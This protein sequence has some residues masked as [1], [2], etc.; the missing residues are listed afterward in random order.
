MYV[1]QSKSYLKHIDFIILDV[2]CSQIALIV[3]YC[4]YNGW[5]KLVYNRHEYVILAELIPAAGSVTTAALELYSGILRRG[6]LKEFKYILIQAGVTS[7]L[8]TSVLFITKESSLYS[9]AILIGTAILFVVIAFPVRLLRKKHLKILEG[10]NNFKEV[11][12][13]AEE[14]KLDEICDNI[15][16]HSSNLHIKSTI[17]IENI[18][19][20]AVKADILQREWI[21]EVYI[22][23]DRKS[24]E[25]K[26][27]EKDIQTMGIVMHT[28]LPIEDDKARNE[29]YEV[30]SGYPVLTVSVNTATPLQSFLKTSMDIAG[31]IAGAF[32]CIIILII[33]GPLVYFKDPGPIIFSQVRIG[34]NGKKFRIYKIRSMYKDAEKRKAELMQDNKMSDGMMFKVDNDPRILPGIGQFIRKT[35]LDEFPQFFNVLKGDMSLVGTRPPTVDEWEKY[36]SRHRLRLAIKPGITG[37]WQVSGRSAITDFEE[38]LKLDTDYIYN[39]SLG[40]DVKILWKTVVQALRGEGAE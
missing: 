14:N 19:S 28:I 38:V 5:D 6:A 30:L 1:R 39:W 32:I 37:L 3:S 36:G 22:A 21:D 15:K 24:E 2:I 29:F 35:S 10:K 26:A 17:A 34:R 7:F 12:V 40:L 11:L 33:I 20:G 16:A 4:M 8:V 18:E 27:F 13:V 31:G 23:S 9:R 25:R